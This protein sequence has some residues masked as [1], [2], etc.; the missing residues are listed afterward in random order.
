M[1]CGEETAAM[2]R[3][4]EAGFNLIEVVVISSLLL[5]AG[6]L[7]T[8]PLV[9]VLNRTKVEGA[10]NDM[11]AL[12]RASRAIA[13]TRGGSAVVCVDDGA[14][15]LI[16]FADVHGVEL[17]DEPDG[18]LN[19]IVGQPERSTDYEIGRVRLPSG[20]A[21]ADPDGQRGLD[22]VAGFA[23]PD[24]LPAGCAIYREDGS[25][26]ATGAFR[27][28]DAR[29]NALELI[30]APRTAARVEVRKWTGTAWASRGE[31]GRGW[32]WD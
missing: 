7:S 11:S 17:D 32:D 13:I 3:V 30:A 20:V 2:R 1:L 18:L 27:L 19:P 22:S 4:S 29:G 26:E 5:T 9:G 21:F 28:A 12:M 6:V 8:P 25:L 15:E 10:A 23:N 24:G 14:G 31:G 16:A